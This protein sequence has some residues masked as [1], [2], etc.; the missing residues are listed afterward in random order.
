M[1]ETTEFKR[2]TEAEIKAWKKA[3][4]GL[5][6]IEVDGKVIILR[7][8]KMKDLERA[9]AADP[10]RQKPYNFHRSIIENCKLYADPGLIEDDKN[11]LA[12]CSK[13]DE[14]VEV[15]EAD[16]KKL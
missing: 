8:P 14:I 12:V 9:Q 3:H 15:R 11:Y 16:L 1:N 4:D 13:L 10:K 6:Q 2:P 5:Y 7:E